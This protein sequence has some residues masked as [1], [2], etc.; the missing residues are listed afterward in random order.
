MA[1]PVRK[2][3]VRA[4][5]R[6]LYPLIRILLRNGLPFNAF[7][8]IA[9][10]VYVDVAMTEFQMPGR[11]AS[12]S[13]TA[14][15]TGL[16][17]KDV[18]RLLE[19]KQP[20]DRADLDRY[21]RAARVVAG[22]VRDADFAEGESP[23][24]LALDGDGPS[25]AE[26]VRRY[27]G[28]MTARSVLDELLNAGT[29]Q[30]DEAGRVQ[31]LARSY[32]P[33]GD[34]LAKVAI[35]GTDVSYLVET[36]NHNLVGATPFYQRKV[37]YDNLPADFVERFRGEAARQC[38]ALIENLDRQLAGHDRDHNPSVGGEGRRFAGIGIYYFERDLEDKDGEKPS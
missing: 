15:V 9:K 3:L 1:T 14:V 27:S 26:L 35:L 23:A 30:L 28:D 12:V 13:R 33:A 31:L 19:E 17:R 20:E 2:A 18:S 32:V 10:A 34:D 6:I 22:W 5:M 37:A 4:V 36:I 16:T 38:Q 21:H 25:F 8:E 11:K 7:A 29:V 24:R